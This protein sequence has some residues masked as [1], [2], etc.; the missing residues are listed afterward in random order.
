MT[1][2]FHPLPAPGDIVWCNFPQ[3][4]DLGQPGP[5]PRPALIVSVAP[6]GHAVE[7]AYGTTQRT[8]KLFPGEFLIAANDPGF[9]DSGLDKD[10]KFDLARTVKL[11]FDSNWF[12]PAPGPYAL[13][14]SPKMGILHASLYT[15][16]SRAAAIAQGKRK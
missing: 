12:A 7:V 6:V 5:K 13:T 8:D 1:N 2:Q 10:T 11:T 14:P 16:A 3:M 4:E 15:R 9:S